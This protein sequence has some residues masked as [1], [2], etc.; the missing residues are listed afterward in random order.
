MIIEETENADLHFDDKNYEKLKTGLVIF[1]E[2]LKDV[3]KLKILTEHIKI[4]CT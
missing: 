3:E 4:L 1:P 2:N